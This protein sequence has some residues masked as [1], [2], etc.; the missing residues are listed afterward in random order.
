ML[1][2]GPFKGFVAAAVV[3]AG[4]SPAALSSRAEAADVVT[5]DVPTATRVDPRGVE[6]VGETATQGLV[7]WR[8]Q[9]DLKPSW[10]DYAGLTVHPDGTTAAV[11]P[12]PAEVFGDRLVQAP[13]GPFDPKVTSRVLPDGDWTDRA[14][15]QGYTL[16]DY[17]ADGI[18]ATSFATGLSLLPWSGSVP[19]EIPGVPNGFSPSYYDSAS[20][21]VHEGAA[22][23]LRVYARDGSGAYHQ[24]LVD[25]AARRAWVLPE[26]G[27]CDARRAGAWGIGSDTLVWRS[28]TAALLCTLSRPNPGQ[29]GAGSPATRPAP[30]LPVADQ[31]ADVSLLSVGDDVVAS[32]RPESGSVPAER[33]MPVLI[34][35]QDGSIESLLRWGHHVRPSGPDS[36]IVVGGDHAES[37]VRRFDLT[38]D[39]VE[40]VLPD[41]PVAAHTAGVALDNRHL[42]LLQ[43]DTA[44]GSTLTVGQRLFDA[45]TGALGDWEPI[46]KAASAGLAVEDG[47]T[48]WTSDGAWAVSSPDGEI[49]SKRLDDG[50]SVPAGIVAMSGPFIHF[51][52]GSVLDTRTNFLSRRERWDTR[53]RAMLDRAIYAPGLATPGGP[54]GSV[55]GRD[56]DSGFA[57]EIP[58]PG[59]TNMH[60]VQAAGTWLL[61]SC[62]TGLYLL[63]RSQGQDPIKLDISGSI[64]LMLGN[65]FLIR[66][67]YDGSLS[68]VS[69][70]AP[71]TWQPLAPAGSADWVAPAA[72]TVAAVAYS[73]GA[74]TRIARL[75]VTPR[76][77]PA[78]AQDVPLPHPPA[79]SLQ[80][81]GNQLTV[82]WEDPTA[83]ERLTG[84]YISING[85][86]A[87]LLSSTARTYTATIDPAG[88]YDVRLLAGNIAGTAAAMAYYGRLA[89]PPAPTNVTATLDP[90]TIKTHVTWD[91]APADG[92]ETARYFTVVVANR[93]VAEM[94]GTARAADFVMPDPW[95]GPVTVY[96]NGIN[97]DSAGAESATLVFP[98]PDVTPP[99]A[100]L[101]TIPQVTLRPS[102]VLHVSGSD[103]RLFARYEIRARTGTTTGG[104]GPWQPPQ[105]ATDLHYRGMASGSTHCFSARAIDAYQNTSEWTDPQCTTV[106]FDD[107]ALQPLTG[108][109]HRIMD[110]RAYRGSS[111]SADSG[112]PSLSAGKHRTDA[113]WLVATTCPTCGKVTV[114][115]SRSGY[116]STVSLRS[117]ERRNLV[118]IKVPWPSPTSGAISLRRAPGG[119]MII[120]DGFAPRSF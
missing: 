34:V 27:A 108:N 86:T 8:E 96:A 111:L 116:R 49:E 62:D 13:Y 79:V 42:A 20:A 68:W 41:D 47:A 59:C 60:S 48:A 118:A 115:D 101:A 76:A 23:V 39:T 57:V 95:T 10:G 85:T 64:D 93:P 16:V 24:V 87:K 12:G 82:S 26:T 83:E 120:L 81:T 109:W 73:D 44:L 50:A 99:V 14:L 1:H 43:D 88:R 36:V 30:P 117:K 78:V 63:D 105:P 100:R 69:L 35:H 33:E 75:P 17:T 53:G 89:P 7:L 113:V 119:G 22:A 15:P 98:G 32:V 58:V 92:A 90:V 21:L 67:W 18:L 74:R 29:V 9:D 72:G 107:R 6:L 52:G 51:G 55:L 28:G 102:L 65:G 4:I 56:L 45:S 110:G 38:D 66:R 84:Y 25:T 71:N 31:L 37:T 80:V 19:I 103:D 54:S 114:S 61:A 106:A 46:S 94:S 3:L 70:D 97:E 5:I 2:G 11:G 91:W 77:T 40:V 104:L 112:K